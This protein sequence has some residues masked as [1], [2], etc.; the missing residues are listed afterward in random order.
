MKVLGWLTH[1]VK[2]LSPST[3]SLV[4]IFPTRVLIYPNTFIQGQYV[5][6]ISAVLQSRSKCIHMCMYILFYSL[7][8]HY[9]I[10][11]MLLYLYI[12][13]MYCLLKSNYQEER[14]GIPLTGLTCHSFAPFESQSMDFNAIHYMSWSFVPFQSQGMD[15]SAI[16]YMSWFFVYVPWVKVNCYFCQYWWNCRQSLFKLCCHNYRF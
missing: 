13:Y 12:L 15:S 11:D 4:I 7:A 16:H 10:P 8:Y 9:F 6:N 5:Y 14:F 1:S 2:K 3:S